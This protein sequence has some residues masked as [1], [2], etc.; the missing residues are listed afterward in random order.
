MALKRSKPR[1]DDTQLD[2]FSYARNDTNLADAIRNDGRET[3]ARV[4]SENG[5]RFGTERAAPGD[6]VGGGG[7]NGERDVRPDA[8]RNEG[9]INGTTS[10]RPILGNGEGEIHPP[11]ARVAVNGHHRER[12]EAPR[13]QANHRITE[14][15]AIGK[16]S[17]KQKCRKNIEA[18]Q[19]LRALE[20]EKRAATGE[21]KSALVKYV[22][23]GGIPQIFDPTGNEEWEE[24]RAALE[25]L[26]TAEEFEAA[27][28]ST[29]NAHYTSP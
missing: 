29:L 20:S 7:E 14:A 22:G 1:A 5:E 28:S 8:E 21:E 6:V 16:G 12:V 13:N 2:L 9:R 11:A 27:R 18:I 4:S 25:S 15:D 3:L 24:E 19:L 10:P 23:W 17:L 26:L